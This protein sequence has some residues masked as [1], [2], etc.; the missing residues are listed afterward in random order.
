MSIAVI[1]GGTRTN[2]NTE[3]LTKKVIQGQ[4]AETIHLKEYHIQPIEDLRHTET[5]FPSIADDYD[6]IIERILP[7]DTLI[8]A[9]PIYWYGMSGTLKI[10]IDRWS[11]TM[12]DQ[13]YPDF[14]ARLATKQAY[15]VA[16]GGDHPRIKGLP[17]I[18]QFAYIFSFVGI[19]FRGYVLGEGNRPGDILEDQQA[20][21]TASGLL[22]GS[23]MR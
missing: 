14:K 5:G 22:N 2:G 13:H 23:A 20:L 6:S 10:F 3:L 18:Q 11:Q 12:R 19:S 16:V 4:D 9:T 7:H 8:F 21:H 15:V 1:N 17:L